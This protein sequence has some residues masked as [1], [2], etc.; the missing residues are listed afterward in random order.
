MNKEIKFLNIITFS[1]LGSIFDTVIE[2]GHRLTDRLGQALEFVN[3][4][5]NQ[6]PVKYFTKKYQ[7]S[8]LEIRKFATKGE[9]FRMLKIGQISKNI[10]TP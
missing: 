10:L 2:F 5:S 7:P 9:I 6:R 3:Y 4:F 8:E 1:R